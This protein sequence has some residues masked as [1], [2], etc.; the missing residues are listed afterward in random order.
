LLN[1]RKQLLGVFT[2]IVFENSPKAETAIV[3]SVLIGVQSKILISEKINFNIS[4]NLRFN[5]SYFIG[6]TFDLLFGKLGFLHNFLY[7]KLVKLFFVFCFL[8][9]EV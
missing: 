4:P 2:G 6:C 5:N 3:P 8:M 7:L 9:V 1:F